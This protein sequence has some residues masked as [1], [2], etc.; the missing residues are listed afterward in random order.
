MLASLLPAEA[1]RKT[2]LHMLGIHGD[3]VAAKKRIAKAKKTGEDLGLNVYGYPRTFQYSP[4]EKEELWLQ[5]ETPKLGIEH[6]IVLDPTAGGGSIP[7]ESLRLGCK[8][9]ANESILSLFWF[10]KPPMSGRLSTVGRCLKSS[11]GSRA[12][13]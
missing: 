13:F 3:P 2:F 4:S 7:F 9:L 10:R 6:P 1:D 11:T 12:V 8:T 5:E